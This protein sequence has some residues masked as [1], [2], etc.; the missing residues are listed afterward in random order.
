[1]RHVNNERLS[2][3]GSGC[4]GRGFYLGLTRI[5]CD[6]ISDHLTHIARPRISDTSSQNKNYIS[7]PG[8]ALT[9]ARPFL[10]RN[11]NDDNYPLK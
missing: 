9:G 3:P 6:T 11:D 4:R 1:M 5:V 7:S 8:S 2:G 10:P